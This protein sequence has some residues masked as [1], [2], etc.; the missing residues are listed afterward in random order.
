MATH[1]F[2]QFSD[3]LLDNQIEELVARLNQHNHSA[4]DGGAQVDHGEL[5]GRTDDDHTQYLLIAGR[6]GGQTARGG[7]APGDDLTI[8]STSNA[9]KGDVY[10]GGDGTTN[11]VTVEPDGTLRFDGN[12]TVW[13]DINLSV[14]SLRP[15]ATAPGRWTIPGTGIDLASFAGSGPAQS[16]HGSLEILHDYKQGS[17]IIPHLHWCPTTNGLGNVKMQLEYQWTNG[18]G[19]I[20][21]SVT[22]SFTAAVSGIVANEQRTSFPAISGAGKTIGSRFV[23]RLFRD[24]ADAAD[25][26]AGDIGTF[27]FGIHY[28]LDTVGSR[29]VT[30][31]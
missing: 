16:A 30:T 6:A 5:L 28:E 2:G 26:Y 31:K 15:G 19:T 12:A 27:D 29:Q 24:S 20:T 3:L 17:D 1:K 25:T 18:G 14:G 13:N 9:T 21:S 23:F 4:S 11:R 8:I 22:I 7:T 10:I